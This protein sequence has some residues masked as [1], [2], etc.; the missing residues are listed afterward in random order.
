[1]S[2]ILF[3]VGSSQPTGSWQQKFNDT[4]WYADF[5]S[6]DSGNQEWDSE[7]SG[8]DTAAQI[9]GDGMGGWEVGYRPTKIRVTFTGSAG[10]YDLYIIDDDDNYLYETAIAAPGIIEANLDW[11]AGFDIISIL[12]EKAGENEPCSITNIEFYEE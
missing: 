5:G 2:A 4:F 9:M 10:T 7:F 1:M 11:S 12:I 6:W 8:G 3:N